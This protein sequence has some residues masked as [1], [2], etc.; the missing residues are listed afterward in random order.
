MEWY[1]NRCIYT[2]QSTIGDLL[3]GESFECNI[4]EDSCRN[5]DKNYDG[6]LSLDEKIYGATAIPSGQYE[7]KM[8][9]SNHFQRKMPHLHSAWVCCTGEEVPGV[10]YLFKDVMIHWA[11]TAI[12]VKGCLA[13]GTKLDNVADWV[14][15]SQKAYND[16][17]PKILDVLKKEPLFLNIRGGYT[18]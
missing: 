3:L 8:C 2:D 14:S 17:E 4:L 5:R 7:I 6:R 9:W 15:A 1:L 10:K 12:Q 18:V 16:L 13:T 11:N